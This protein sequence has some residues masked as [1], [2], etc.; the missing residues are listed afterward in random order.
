MAKKTTAAKKKTT[1]KAAAPKA[2]GKA[3]AA[4]PKRVSA[5]DAAHTVLVKAGGAMASKELIAAMAD[6]GLWS[7]PKGKTPHAPLY[8]ALLREI[9]A[10]GKDARFR[11]VE[12]GQFEAIGG[13]K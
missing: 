10:K 6:K 2:S 13:G 4:K 5:L 8:A 7:S 9:N 1:K 11:K 12:R 3:K